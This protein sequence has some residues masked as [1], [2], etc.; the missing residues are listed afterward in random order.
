MGLP[1]AQRSKRRSPARPPTSAIPA[2]FKSGPWRPWFELR[3]SLL[4]SRSRRECSQWQQ[5]SYL[6][7]ILGTSPAGAAWQ[8]GVPGAGCAW[9]GA[10]VLG[11]LSSELPSAHRS[12]SAPATAGQSLHRKTGSHI[13]PWHLPHHSSAPAGTCRGQMH[14]LLYT[15]VQGTGQRHNTH[16]HLY[17]DTTHMSTRRHRHPTGICA[18]AWGG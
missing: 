10:V 5:F 11:T 13:F 12:C 4:V 1:A 17:T 3:T 2:N 15:A 16:T 14:S 9:R 6:S 7:F 8:A 18:R